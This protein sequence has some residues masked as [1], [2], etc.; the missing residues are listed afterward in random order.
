MILIDTDGF[1]GR[2]EYEMRRVASRLG[3]GYVRCAE[4]FV[5]RWRA[6]APWRRAEGHDI[7]MAGPQRGL[8]DLASLLEDGNGV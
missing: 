4:A 7:P 8:C 6:T 5:Q 2:Y 3:V 1:E